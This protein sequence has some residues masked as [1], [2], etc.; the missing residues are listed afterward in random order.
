[1]LPELLKAG[2][3]G[4]I[5]ALVYYSYRAIIKLNDSNRPTTHIVII[6]LL[7][8]FVNLIAG[9][10]G[11]LWASKELEA[12]VIRRNTASILNSQIDNFSIE[13]RKSIAPIQ[14]AL[15]DVVSNLKYSVLESDRERSLNE[16]E[17][18]NKMLQEREKTFTEKINSLKNT[19]P[20]TPDK[21]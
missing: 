11:Y 17:R 21:E 8:F 19:F 5:A 18:M 16:M 15:D 13:Y 3:L 7:F 14:N 2:Y 4:L 9:L 12:T 1:M 10:A 20:E 6:I